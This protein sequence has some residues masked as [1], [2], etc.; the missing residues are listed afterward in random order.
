[1]VKTPKFAGPPAQGV[2]DHAKG[3]IIFL[4][5]NTTAREKATPWGPR[6]GMNDPPFTAN[7]AHI[8]FQKFWRPF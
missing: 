7:T 5:Y 4:R 8:D 2:L 1:M 6:A 3:I